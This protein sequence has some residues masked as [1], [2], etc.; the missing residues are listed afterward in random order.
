MFEQHYQMLFRQAFSMLHDAEESRDMVHDVFAYLL[1]HPFMTLKKETAEKYLRTSV[2]NRCLNVMRN[3]QIQM[4]I[5][6]MYLLEQDGEFL[7][8]APDEDELR[9]L[10]Q[11]MEHLEPPTCRDVV[12]MHFDEGMK[13]REAEFEL[14]PGDSL[15]LYTD[16]VA[17]AANAENELYGTDRMIDALNRHADEAVEELLPSMKREIDAFVGDAPQFDD[18]TMLALRYFGTRKA[19]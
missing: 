16:G 17:E 4:R 15:Y 19:E 11:A 7:P 3:R 18:I 5:S 8:I 1:Q 10:Q 2:R 13:F 14:C 9:M 6:R 12:R